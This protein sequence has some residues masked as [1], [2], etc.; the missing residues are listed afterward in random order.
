MTSFSDEKTRLALL[1]TASLGSGKSNSVKPLSG[2]EWSQFID[3]MSRAELDCSDLLGRR[4]QEHLQHFTSPNIS[5][6]RIQA[7]FKRATTLGFAIDRYANLGVWILE[8][9]SE[10]YPERLRQKLGEKSPPL[11]FGY[12]NTHNLNCSHAVGV[13]GSRNPTD[14][15]LRISTEIGEKTALQKSV[16]VSGGARGIDRTAAAG[17]LGS[18]GHVVGVLA[19]SLSSV[20]SRKENRIELGDSGKLTL[21]TQYDPDSPFTVGKAMGRN[22]TIYALADVAVVVAS[23]RGSGG[24][25]NGATQALKL[26]TTH[27]YAVPSNR[28]TSGFNALLDLGAKP[29]ELPYVEIEPRYDHSNSSERTAAQPEIDGGIEPSQMFKWF[30]EIAIDE[31]RATPM[32]IRELSRKIYVIEQQISAWMKMAVDQ[33]H[34]VVDT[35]SGVFRVD[36]DAEQGRLN[37]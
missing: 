26:R 16:L 6:E 19:D 34:F 15:E 17:A 2:K 24:T 37:L 31:I 18:D 32:T 35:K 1:A 20:G 10:N 8:R 29:V 30:L 5:S 9:D 4:S 7:L 28:K 22:A 36:E 25:W 33:G 23:E 13:V 3:W 21:V 27:I 11:L 14:R 12:G